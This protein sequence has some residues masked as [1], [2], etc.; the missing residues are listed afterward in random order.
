[1]SGQTR[2]CFWWICAHGRG[3]SY[4]SF[5]HVSEDGELC[6][7]GGLRAILATT[8]E[9]DVVMLSFIAIILLDMLIVHTA[10]AFS[11]GVI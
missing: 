1:M 3:T 9:R 8:S 4:I 6:L 11:H 10:M 7:F 2:G 5:Y